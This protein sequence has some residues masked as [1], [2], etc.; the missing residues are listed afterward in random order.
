MTNATNAVSLC[1]DKRMVIPALFVADGVR[2]FAT[3]GRPFF[4]II[5]FAPREDVNDA[6]REWA[7]SRKIRFCHEIDTSRIDKLES[8]QKRFPMA[9]VMRLLVPEFLGNHY[10]KILHLDADLS[11]HG[12]VARLFQLE[13]GNLPIAAVPGN[14]V[15]TGEQVLWDWWQSH[16]ESLGMTF[17]YRPFNAGVMLINTETWRRQDLTARTLQFIQQQT[18][19]FP[20]ED[21]LNSILDGGIVEISPIWNLLPSASFEYATQLLQPVIIH[22]AGTRKPWVRYG[23]KR[24]LLHTNET[25]QLYK[26]FL[27]DTPWSNWLSMQ[28]STRDFLKSARFEARRYLKSK[29][30]HGLNGDD[31]KRALEKHLSEAPFADIEQGISERIGG[32]IRLAANS[33]RENRTLN[34]LRAAC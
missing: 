13:M 9:N 19:Y 17:P 14:R 26:S 15:F 10:E 4:D 21:A 30:T 27:R 11:I 16:Y 3:G 7:K 32:V 18:R 20:N 23:K 1:V 8:A 25:Y 29:K 31:V 33:S 22:H 24:R 5:I 28:W 34:G 2:K 6:H 12:D